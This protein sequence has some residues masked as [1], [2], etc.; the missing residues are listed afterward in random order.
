[1]SSERL[2]S[3]ISGGARHNHMAWS[4]NR[5][6][7][8]DCDTSA[9]LRKGHLSHQSLEGFHAGALK[10]Y[11]ILNVISVTLVNPEPRSRGTHYC[12]KGRPDDTERGMT[13]VSL[14]A[15]GTTCIIRW[16]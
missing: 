9:G 14:H 1:M 8:A 12:G 15:S 5:D 13:T 4:I 16:I 6:C 7:V 10:V 11:F 3:I 2:Y